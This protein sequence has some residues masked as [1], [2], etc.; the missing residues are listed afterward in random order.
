V[1]KLLPSKERPSSGWGLAACLLVLIAVV[2]S[3]C[4]TVTRQIETEE[5]KMEHRP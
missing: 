2:V 1:T 5:I 4:E 3:M